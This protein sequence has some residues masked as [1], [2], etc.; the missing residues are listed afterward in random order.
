[1]NGLTYTLALNLGEV[2]KN[3]FNVASE[4][5]VKRSFACL[6]ANPA[7]IIF[8][9][10]VEGCVSDQIVI[11]PAQFIYNIQRK[12]AYDELK[13]DL[14]AISEVLSYLLVD[15][16]EQMMTLRFVDSVDTNQDCMKKFSSLVKVDFDDPHLEGIEG[17]GLRFFSKTEE[18]LFNEF[19]A[20]PLLLDF[21]Q[22]YFEGLYNYTAK[23]Y[24]QLSE[25]YLLAYKDFENKAKFFGEKYILA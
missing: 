6:I 5:M 1:M 21:T 2:P 3:V 23:Q 13:E 8:E 4:L 7:A 18:N 9:R 16:N 25:L 12:F 14:N 22:L 10:K 15:K 17:V 11:M 24:K 20:E 19:K